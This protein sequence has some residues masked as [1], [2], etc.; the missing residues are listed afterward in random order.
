MKVLILLFALSLTACSTFGTNWEDAP[1]QYQ[2]TAEQMT[3]VENETRFCAKETGYASERCYG[4]AMIRNC[5]RV[6]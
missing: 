5:K 1:M 3:K 4:T 6:Q 2:C